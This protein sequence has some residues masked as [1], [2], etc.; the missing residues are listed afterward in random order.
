MVGRLVEDEE[1]G[2]HDERIGQCHA[3][4]LSAGQL[5]KGL[6]PLGD[7]ELR[8]DGLGACLIVPCL[9]LFHTVQD[10][11][12]ARLVLGSH[13]GLILADEVGRLVAVPE[14]GLDDGQVEGI[15]GCLLQIADAQV[16]AED[17]LPLVGLIRA[18][19]DVE[20]R[21]FACTV[22]GDKTHFL[23]FADAEAEV[24]EQCL[25]P[26]EQCL[27]PHTARQILYL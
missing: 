2:L 21:A 20:Q 10:V 22:L 18:I 9:L 23:S 12:Q 5:R 27:V 24:A 11:L 4:Q 16:V 19:Q 6:P 8:E 7:E 26:Y 14:A 1:V 25:V 13:T 3:L 15:V 17:H